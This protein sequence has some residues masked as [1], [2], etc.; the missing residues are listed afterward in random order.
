MTTYYTWGPIPMKRTGRTLKIGLDIDGMDITIFPREGDTVEGYS[1]ADA[2]RMGLFDRADVLV[3]RA[4]WARDTVSV[5]PERVDIFVGKVGEATVSGVTV[6]LKAEPLTAVLDTPMPRNLFQAPCTN[7]L[8]DA[9]CGL[10]P[11]DWDVSGTV[12]SQSTRKVIKLA[13]AAASKANN[14]FKLGWVEFTSG[15]YDGVKRRIKTH[16]G[17]KIQMFPPLASTPDVGTTLK[18]WPGCA[19][20]AGACANKFDNFTHFRGCPHIPVAETAV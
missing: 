17:G 19:R 11:D 20:T 15:D 9:N 8:F 16:S 2:V 10:D 6:T 7:M 4:F 12:A 3:E 13:G 5:D 1:Y 18:V 14:W